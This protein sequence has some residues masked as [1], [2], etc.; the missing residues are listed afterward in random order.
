MAYQTIDLTWQSIPFTLAYNRHYCALSG[1]AHV[2]IHCEEA[3]PL[4]ETGYRSIF[5]PAVTVPEDIVELSDM[6]LSEMDRLSSQSDWQDQRQM[7][8]F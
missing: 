2:T 7:S 3:L 6:I 8:L 5:T 1:M 4:T